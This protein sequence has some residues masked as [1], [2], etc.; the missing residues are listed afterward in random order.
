MNLHANGGSWESIP[1]YSSQH[2]QLEWKILKTQSSKAYLTNTPTINKMKSNNESRSH[3]LNLKQWEEVSDPRRRRYENYSISK[4]KSKPIYGKESNTNRL[5]LGD[6]ADKEDRSPSF[7]PFFL[8]D[9]RNQ[10]T[11][12]SISFSASSLIVLFLLRL[13]SLFSGALSSFYLPEFRF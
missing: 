4:S 13:L 8:A 7:L 9:R 1:L 6:D 10:M 12:L 5:L 2:T 3:L 11:F